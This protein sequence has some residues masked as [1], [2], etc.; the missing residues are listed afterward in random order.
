MER[1]QRRAKALVASYL[2]AAFAFFARAYPLHS[3][4]I[5]PTVVFCPIPPVSVS[6]NI[7]AAVHHLPSSTSSL[8]HQTPISP[9][10]NNLPPI[11]INTLTHI[12]LIF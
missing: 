8:N 6:K 5:W 1:Q 7:F 11:F 9:F 3:T 10:C 2:G 12:L 4:S